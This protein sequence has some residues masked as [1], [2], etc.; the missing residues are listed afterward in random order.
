MLNLFGQEWDIK[1]SVTI[2]YSVP[3]PETRDL[4]CVALPKL[5]SNFPNGC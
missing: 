2:D 5:C 3:V 1:C 4:P